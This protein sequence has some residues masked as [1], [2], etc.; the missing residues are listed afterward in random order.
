MAKLSN[1]QILDLAYK[2][3]WRESGD[4]ERVLA[5]VLAESGGN[6]DAISS[7]GCCHG[8]MQI[9]VRAHPQYTVA[10][11]HQAEPNM[12]AGFALWTAR[13]NWGDWNSSRG[14]QLLRGPEARASMETWTLSPG[15]GAEGTAGAIDKAVEAVP[16]LSTISEGVARVTNWISTPSNIGRVALVVIGALVIV[17]AFSRIT[18]GTVVQTTAKVAD[19]AI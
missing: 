7:T 5:I 17:V 3:G 2:V 1:H 19:I 6:T 10:Q 12:Q 9:N 14:G 16:G 8:L 15:V 13:G 4:L 11:M 18:P